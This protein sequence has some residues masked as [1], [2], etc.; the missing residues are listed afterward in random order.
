[1]SKDGMKEHYPSA[2]HHIQID[3]EVAKQM[4]ENAKAVI[5]T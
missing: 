2:K 4:A 1:M 3:Q 5:V